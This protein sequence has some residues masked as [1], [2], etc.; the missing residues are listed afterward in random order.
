MTNYIFQ[1]NKNGET[2]VMRA[3]K[4][5]CKNIQSFQ[6][7]NYSVTQQNLFCDIYSNHKHTDSNINFFADK[8]N[9][10]KLKKPSLTGRDLEVI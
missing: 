6:L 2:Y 3:F 4:R 1:T 10:F 8:M 9:F 5:Y 7:L